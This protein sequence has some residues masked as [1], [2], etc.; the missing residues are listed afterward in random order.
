MLDSELPQPHRHRC[1]RHP[2]PPRQLRFRDI[3]ALI[4][5]PLPLPPPGLSPHLFL[6]GSPHRSSPP[7]PLDLHHDLP[8]SCCA[9]TR[10]AIRYG[11]ENTSHDGFSLSYFSGSH[12]ALSPTSLVHRHSHLGLR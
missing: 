10:G 2:F 8:S 12:R 4:E 11:R 7:E 5:H 9:H 3:D 6:L 1:P